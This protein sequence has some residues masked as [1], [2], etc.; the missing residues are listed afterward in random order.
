MQHW[1]RHGGVDFPSQSKA[2]ATKNSGIS[3]KLS[4]DSAPFQKG[5]KEADKQ[6]KSFSTSVKAL[7]PMKL[8]QAS[9]DMQS[10]TKNTQAAENALRRLALAQN[11]VFTGNTSTGP[12][13]RFAVPGAMTPQAAAQAARDAEKATRAI[14]INNGAV[15][16]Y[17]EDATKKTKVLNEEMKKTRKELTATTNGAT[18]AGMGMLMLSQT[19]DDAQYGFR[20]VVN[21]IAPLVM[22]LG[23]GTGLAGAL[24]IAAVGFNLLGDRMEEFIGTARKARQI[25]QESWLR[26]TLRDRAMMGAGFAGE[27]FVR[28]AGRDIER[29]D[30][31]RN[32]R[33]AGSSR[34]EEMR[35]MGR[36]NAALRAGVRRNPDAD[37]DA[38]LQLRYENQL[39]REG[40]NASLAERRGNLISDKD[41]A[42]L[43]LSGMP[44]VDAMINELRDL[45]ANES[46]RTKM[47]KEAEEA[48][49]AAGGE[50]SGKGMSRRIELMPRIRAAEAQN[51]KQAEL[52][53]T[54]PFL[55][56]RRSQLG[57]FLENEAPARQAELEDE[58]RK[59]ALREE[60]RQLKERQAQ[61]AIFDK[62]NRDWS[63]GVNRMRQEMNEWSVEQQKAVTAIRMEIQARRESGRQLEADSR[64]ARLRAGGSTRRA[65]RAQAGETQRRRI[66]ELLATGQYTPEQAEEIA[67]RENPE[68]G[69]IRR[70]RDNRP[71]SGAGGLDANS[72]SALDAFRSR[73]GSA[74]DS[75]RDGNLPTPKEAAEMQ[76]S[77]KNA[78]GKDAKGSPQ[79]TV[80][81]LLSDAGN[82]LS[83]ILTA[84]TKTPAERAQPINR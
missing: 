44:D 3:A 2:M 59:N 69:R 76:K 48:I 84:V 41:A 26:E 40:E 72:P 63:E 70:G 42:R 52:E 65:D 54:V 22:G 24:T 10:F 6:L 60:T 12:A 53:K 67:R 1:R 49:K 73:R 5:L 64:I 8:D 45:K 62:N 74:L 61:Q 68:T 80:E 46:A 23:G 25:A 35:Q 75:F 37:Y 78:P 36:D 58:A 34:A 39:A 71:N 66:N 29:R 31:E 11:T 27:D 15:S 14:L 20:G 17:Q 16:R 38:F 57:N 9:R 47:L 79:S 77:R 55:R 13:R 33:D 18:N 43:E 19:I 28:R 82:T 21:N 51:A 50:T 32:A 4:L 81:K 30:A 56:D 83:Q 7:P